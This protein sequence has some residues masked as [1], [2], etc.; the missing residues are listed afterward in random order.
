[1]ADAFA[2]L[3]AGVTFGNARHSKKVGFNQKLQHEK[4]MLDDDLM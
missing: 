3:T 2:L 4:Q 1:M